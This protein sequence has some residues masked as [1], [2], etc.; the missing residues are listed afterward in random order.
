MVCILCNNFRQRLLTEINTLKYLE[1]GERTL[2][3]TSAVLGLMAIRHEPLLLF[4]LFLVG[5]CKVFINFA[6]R[7]NEWNEAKV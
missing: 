7:K 2:G 6:V 4:F 3:K 1:W 5:I